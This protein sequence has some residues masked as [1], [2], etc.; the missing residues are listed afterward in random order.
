ML[1][2]T[3]VC[4]YLG[5]SWRTLKNV[6]TV[7]PVDMGASVVRYNRK[8]ID[9]WVEARPAR[10]SERPTS[11]TPEASSEGSCI[12]SAALERARRRGGRS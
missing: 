4:E 9:A 10:G 3:E 2:R 6:L 12:V 7:Q 5:L 8:Q 11:A 1:T